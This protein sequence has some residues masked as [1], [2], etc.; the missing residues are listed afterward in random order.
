MLVE[1]KFQEIRYSLSKRFEHKCGCKNFV[2]IVLGP[3]ST[4][5]QK[6]GLE[7][8]EGLSMFDYVKAT[9]C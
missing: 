7:E 6:T 8:V 5:G 9:S 3:T 4:K 1:E 2:C